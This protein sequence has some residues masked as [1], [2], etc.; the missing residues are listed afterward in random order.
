MAQPQDIDDPKFEVVKIGPCS[1]RKLM[2]PEGLQFKCD[3]FNTEEEDTADQQHD[4]DD[5][6]TYEGNEWVYK[7][8]VPAVFHK[9]IIGA[10]GQAKQRLEMQSGARIVMPNR[11]NKEDVI[12][13]HGRQREHIYS[14]KAQIELLCER[15]EG[16]VEY[17]HFLSL[18]LAHDATFQRQVEKFRE[19]VVLE[20]FSDVDASIFMPA[21]R[22]HFTLT[23]LKLHSHA[24]VEEMKTALAEVAAKISDS[25]DFRL[26]CHAD[27]QGLHILTDDPSNVEVVFTTDRST[28]LQNRIN[29]MANIIFD[30][31][32]AR[33]LISHQNL[34]AQ[35]LLT[36]D[37]NSAEI[38]MHATLMNTKYNKTNRR[39]DGRR[40][41]RT[42]FN[43]GAVMEKF[44]QVRFGQVQLRDIQLSCLDEMGNDGYYNCLY[45]VPISAS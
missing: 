24:Q 20:R 17:T 25:A 18:P 45:S 9:F 3:R 34:M 31:L 10:R 12:W 30:V 28:A 40:G 11:E 6:M 2:I 19:N 1:Y 39:D 26:S 22:M 35:R 14:A 38:K 43:A 7:F 41:E 21:K 32:K 15:E 44:G 37:G 29:S 27:L 8:P 36:S 42:T 13:L 33:N 4:L 23:M 16:K 5:E